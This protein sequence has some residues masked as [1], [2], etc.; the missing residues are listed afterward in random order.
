MTT[1]QMGQQKSC[2]IDLDGNGGK[3]KLR[4]ITKYDEYNYITE[5]VL[6]VNN[7]KH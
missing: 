2:Q 6:Y 4:L 1:N 7:K 5:S 3:E